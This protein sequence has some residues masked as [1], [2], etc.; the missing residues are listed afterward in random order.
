LKAKRALKRQ[1]QAPPA[2]APTAKKGRQSK[3]R[4]DTPPVKEEKIEE[5]VSGSRRRTQVSFYGN[6]TPTVAALKR[7]ASNSTP[8]TSRSTR[9][10]RSNQVE[11]EPTVPASS[12]P[13]RSQGKGKQVDTKPA[14]LPRGTR[15]SRRLR[16]TEDE[17]QQV[18]SEWLDGE[19]G[20]AF[21][22]KRVSRASG[23]YGNGNG[24]KRK[25]PVD[26]DE[27]ELSELSDEEER[28]ETN[29]HSAASSELSELEDEEQEDVAP[30]DEDD[31]DEDF[32]PT[33]DEPLPANEE[34]DVDMLEDSVKDEDE[35]EGEDDDNEEPEDEIKLAIKAAND[36][37]DG[38]IEWEAVSLSMV[39]CPVLT[40]RYVLRYTTGEHSPNNLP[41]LV[42]PTKRLYTAFS[43][44]KL[45]RPSLQ[46]LSRNS[47]S[48][49]GRKQS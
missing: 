44:N 41:N 3:N 43:P 2:K 17:W 1:R 46:L 19:G 27:S 20:E 49:L 29:G 15:V 12:T 24:N 28:V 35:E 8:S 32:S 16:D 22:S 5:P 10:T 13:S 45:V 39:S 9:A 14:S 31:K 38:F 25:L 37:P 33:S 42:I 7:G 30:K 11:N 40:C 23:G 47:R 34:S 36:L 18:P 48:S 26:D 6:V 4:E 21:N